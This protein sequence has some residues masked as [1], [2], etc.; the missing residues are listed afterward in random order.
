MCY[1]LQATSVSRQC[2]Q[3]GNFLARFSD[4][5]D[6]LRDFIS[7]K[8]LATN[9]RLI[10]IIR[11]KARNILYC[12]S[13]AAKSHRSPQLLCSSAGSLPSPLARL[14]RRQPVCGGWL[15]QA[16]VDTV[17][18]H[19][20]NLRPDS[21]CSLCF[22]LLILWL[23]SLSRF[24]WYF[25]DDNLELLSLDLLSHSFVPD[26]DVPLSCKNAQSSFDLLPPFTVFTSNIFVPVVSFWLFGKDFSINLLLKIISP[27]LHETHNQ[28]ALWKLVCDYVINM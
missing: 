25:T 15:G 13:H 3:H 24:D 12:N 4:F 7:K 27:S 9:K 1:E 28:W 23:L 14:C 18:A 16:G 26:W 21:C 11:G 8:R 2:C 10:Q 6:P 20:V 19:S 5:S 22:D 17:A